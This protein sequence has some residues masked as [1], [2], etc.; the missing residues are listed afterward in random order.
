MTTRPLRWRR[1]AIRLAAST[2]IGAVATVGVA[3]ACVFAGEK[4]VSPMLVSFGSAQDWPRSVPAGWPD[5]ANVVAREHST[6]LRHA[7]AIA[8]TFEESKAPVG[9]TVI[10]WRLYACHAGFPFQSLRCTT[11]EV[12]ERQVHWTNGAKIA[13][14]LIPLIPS[15]GF[16]LGTAFYAAIA[17][18]LWSAPAAIRRQGRR[19]RG[20]CPACG[21]DLSG[22]P[23]PTCP[24][25]GA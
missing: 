13:E 6:G 5:Q 15:P 24:E 7:A 2:V 21:Y 12:Q 19:A 18:T 10:S 3:W 23:F 11:Y 25:C 22:A 20:R 16:A 8:I 9:I 14:R 17:F 1:L 4:P